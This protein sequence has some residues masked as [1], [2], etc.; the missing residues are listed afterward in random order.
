M[1]FKEYQQKI[2]QMPLYDQPE[3]GLIGEVGEVIE[4]IKKDRRLGSKRKILEKAR[5][6]EELTDVLWYLVRLASVYHI[7][8]QKAAED[9][10]TK[11]NERHGIKE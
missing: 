7:D 2:N 4:L 8:F 9:N 3:L 6:E 1:N 10:I 11:L 5:L